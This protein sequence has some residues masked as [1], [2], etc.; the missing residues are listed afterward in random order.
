MDSYKERIERLRNHMVVKPSVSVERGK[1]WTDSYK[2][3]E[4][5]EPFY[6]QALALEKTLAAI[7]IQIDDDELLAGRITEFW[8]GSMLLPEINIQFLETEMDDIAI[9]PR[10]TFEPIPQDKQKVIWEMLEYWKQR[11]LHQMWQNK[12][13]AEMLEHEY[14]GLIGG[15]TFC[16]NGHYLTHV[17][18]DYQKLL[19]VG[20]LGIRQEI[21]DEIAGLDLF[22]PENFEK[23]QFLEAALIANKAA[24]GFAR[25]YADLAAEKAKT[26]KDPQRKAE[27][28]EMARI[29][30]KVP[31]N[32]A[33]TF[34]EAI[35]SIIMAWTLINIEG[36]GNGLCFGR[37]DQILYP[38]YKSEKE[39]G[40]LTDDFVLTLISMLYVKTNGVVNVYNR[41]TSNIFT[42][43]PQT[44]NVNVGGINKYGRDAV[45]ELSYLFLDADLDVRLTQNDI[46]VRVEKKTPSDFVIRAIEVAKALRGKVKFMSDETILQQMMHDGYSLDDARNYVITG[47]STVNVAGKS[48]DDPGALLNMPLLLEMSMYD[49]KRRRDGAQL[50]PRTGDARK[51]TSYE[52]LWNAFR[53][54]C[55]HL[56]RYAVPMRSEDR[57]MYGKY[58]PVLFHSCLFNGPIQKGRDMWDDGSYY[59]RL[60][61]SPSGVP[62]VGDSLAAIKK[63]VFEDKAISM[64]ELLN[65]LEADFEGHEKTLKLLGDAPKYGNDIDYVD[66]IVNDVLMMCVDIITPLRC[67]GNALATVSPA[68]LSANV[69]LGL[70]VSALPDGRKAFLPLAEGGVSPYQ[71][72]NVSGPV[73]TYAS[74]AKLDHVKLTNGS[75]FNMRFSPK[76]LDDHP[77]IKK[78]EQMLRTFLESGGFFVQFNIVDTETLRA[79]QK[80][81]DDYKDLLVRVATYSA[82]FVELGEDLQDDIIN[83]LAQDA[84]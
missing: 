7:T 8:R 69:S 24:I 44:M 26:A 19:R 18:C 55:E 30:A 65:A 49:G 50:G 10:C 35:Q 52:E 40:A 77:K 31:A 29:C 32:P 66:K 45:N 72:R 4:G 53:K 56:F 75:I 12:I 60:S 76:E 13:P 81:P 22:V 74:V 21:E 80:N 37:L 20:L 17:S 15:A 33:E 36:Q 68:A 78:F 46:V 84:G 70:D 41:Y 82:Y 38:F 83:R 59:G 23:L 58:R 25:R 5:R 64:D 27:L 14:S 3:T 71:G 39:A 28:E 48:L 51:F 1:L 42:G 47:C 57:Y 16:D 9:R 2:E 67:A 43:W 11:N 54:Q 6:R 34:Y 63:V 79:A 61:Y 73:A 62:N